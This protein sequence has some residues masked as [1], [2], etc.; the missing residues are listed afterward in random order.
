MGS[1][2]SSAV[3]SLCISSGNL[4][5]LV[6]G[7]CSGSENSSLPV[8]MP[9][10][11]YSQQSAVVTLTGSINNLRCTYGARRFHISRSEW[12]RV[13]S[14]LTVVPGAMTEGYAGVH[15]GFGYGARN[16]EGHAI[17]DFATAHDLEET[18]RIVK[19]AES[20]Q[21]K[22][23]LPNTA[24]WHWTFYLRKRSALP[25]ILWKNLMGDATEEF[26]YRVAEGVSTRVEDLAACD[27]DSMWNNLTSI[28][29]DA[30]KDTLGVLIGTSKTYTARRESWWRCEEVQS[31]V[32]V[33]QARF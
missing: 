10:A 16:E 33:K 31:S 11:F 14:R 3:A 18:S 25:R 22:H 2:S 15:G 20:S 21:E 9:C 8:G 7:S 12:D 19:T 1:E 13:F 5:S 17:L 32:V 6:V 28:I 29:K 4:S 30:V 26:K 23:A 24:C 27:A